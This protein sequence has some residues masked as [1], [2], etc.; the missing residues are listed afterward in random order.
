[1]IS[2]GQCK[3]CGKFVDVLIYGADSG[4]PYGKIGRNNFRCLLQWLR[5]V[6][7]NL[8][9]KDVTVL[10]ASLAAVLR[11]L[12]AES[13]V[14]K[15]MT[16]FHDESVVPR[17]CHVLTTWSSG[18]TKATPTIVSLCCSI[19]LCFIRDDGTVHHVCRVTA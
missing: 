9:T 5:A 3:R 10:E 13:G 15:D 8:T 1:V 17:V 16:A 19:L 18:P 14:D 7:L 6:V 2:H 12:T 4:S 11:L